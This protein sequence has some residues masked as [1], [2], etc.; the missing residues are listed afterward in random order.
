MHDKGEQH[1]YAVIYLYVATRILASI[2]R[3]R[4]WCKPARFKREHTQR[5]ST[6][7]LRAFVESTT[8][9]KDKTLLTC[10]T[11]ERCGGHAVAP[12]LVTRVVQSVQLPRAGV[13][14]VQQN[15]KPFP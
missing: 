13:V 9:S 14:S 7:C 2:C 15:H 10:D 12:M 11:V 8:E 4:Y 1:V 3:T 5:N 6:R